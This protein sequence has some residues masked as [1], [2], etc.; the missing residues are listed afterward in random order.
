MKLKHTA[1]WVGLTA[2]VMVA[3][4][5][6]GGGS[7]KDTAKE[8]GKKAGTVADKGV[9]QIKAALTRATDRTEQVGSA[10]VKMTTD[11]GNGTSV[12]SE[13][14]Y[15][16]GDGFAFDLELDTAQAN[17]QQLQDDPKMRMLFVD[18]AY[19]YDIDPQPSGP[20]AGKEWMKLDGSALF[21]ESGAQAMSGSNGSPSASM[22]G[23]K[24]ADDVKDLGSETVNG[25]STEHY[26]AVIGPEKMGQ[27]KDALSGDDSMMG[28]V[29]GGAD[30]IV[31]EVW[32]GDD[33]LPVRLVEEIGRLTVSMDFE[34]FGRTA[35]VTA[36]PA[37]ETGDLTE[38]FKAAQQKQQG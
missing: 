7:A 2:A 22:K 25:K 6:C 26:R 15:S 19:Y 34:K 3:T 4:A 37:S 29:T 11:L 17:M 21:G 23:L 30:S 8:A 36:P 10:Q 9:A 13:G 33:D 16:W 5:A 28:A 20:I 27:F 14:T 32:V 31:M 18:G 1:A 35:R 38:Q 12:A 24:Y